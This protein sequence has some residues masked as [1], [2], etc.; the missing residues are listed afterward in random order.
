MTISW[1]GIEARPQDGHDVRDVPVLLEFDVQPDPPGARPQH[2]GEQR[3]PDPGGGFDLVTGEA[4]HRRAADQRVVKGDQLAVAG[5]AD[6]ELDHVGTDVDRVRERRDGVLGGPGRNPPVR[7]NHGTDHDP[8]MPCSGDAPA[9]RGRTR[10]HAPLRTKIPFIPNGC[11]V[12]ASPP[13]G[14]PACAAIIGLLRRFRPGWR[15]RPARS[16]LPIV[17]Y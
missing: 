12:P 15:R 1:A 14:P 13:P 17:R 4:A 16:R 5:P 10:G 11:V 8:S 7:G 9:T 2:L 3:R 6:I